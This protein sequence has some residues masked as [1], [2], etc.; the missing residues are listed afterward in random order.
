MATFSI[1]AHLT[2][3]THPNLICETV[4]LTLK[5][6]PEDPNEESKEQADTIHDLV[7]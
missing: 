7:N 3:T 6:A 2:P 5:S 1:Y 4:K